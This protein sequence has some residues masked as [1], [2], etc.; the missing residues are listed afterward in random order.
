MNYPYCTRCHSKNN[1]GQKVCGSCK[2][3]LAVAT[4]VNTAIYF[5]NR[6]KRQ[7]ARYLGFKNRTSFYTLSQSIPEIYN[8]WDEINGK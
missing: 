4:Q 5:C 8:A 6:N 2:V 3:T 1:L 7:N